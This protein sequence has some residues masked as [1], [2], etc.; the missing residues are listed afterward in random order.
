MGL[1]KDD[2]VEGIR[3]LDLEAALKQL[4]KLDALTDDQRGE[5]ERFGG[6][7]ENIALQMRQAT[8]HLEGE[9]EG[10]ADWLY[11]PQGEQ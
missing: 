5:L 6:R 7:L 2:N 8:H 11:N 10:F 9:Y 1:N 3:I 4:S